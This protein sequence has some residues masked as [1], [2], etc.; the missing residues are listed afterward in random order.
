[1]NIPAY[2]AVKHLIVTKLA[3]FGDCRRW[4][5][6]IKLLFSESI[7][8]QNERETGQKRRNWA[9]VRNQHGLDLL[10]W[11]DHMD[12]SIWQAR[13]RPEVIA[14]GD[15]PAKRKL[16]PIRKRLILRAFR[17]SKAYKYTLEEE[18]R[19]TQNRE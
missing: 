11:A 18:E 5:H 2:V 12:V 19:E 3:R 16:S 8:E 13:A 9:K 6:T 15:V 7:G 14:H 1:M 4:Y 10:T 17:H